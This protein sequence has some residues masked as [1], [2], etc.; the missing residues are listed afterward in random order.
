MLIWTASSITIA[1]LVSENFPFKD[2]FE[3]ACEP[4]FCSRIA[5]DSSVQ[6]YVGFALFLLLGFHLYDSHWRYVTAINIWQRGI[7]SKL[8]VLSIRIFESYTDSLWHS[9]DLERIAAHLAAFPIALM[10]E[11]RGRDYKEKFEEIL[12]DED[13]RRLLSTTERANYYIDVLQ[14]YLAEEDRISATK[15]TLYP[16]G[17][18]EVE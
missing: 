5:L 18:Q 15:G 12:G 3:K 4:W 8:R 1:W 6:E 14:N 13:S 7:V 17:G 16:A 9:R 10:G 11:L 2:Q